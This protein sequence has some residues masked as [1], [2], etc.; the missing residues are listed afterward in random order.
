[1]KM[2]TKI[3]ILSSV[4][5]FFCAVLLTS[6][7]HDDN[8]VNPPA[9]DVIFTKDSLSLWMTSPNQLGTDSSVFSLGDNTLTKVK[10]EFEVISN[11]DGVN[12][13]GRFYVL[14]NVSPLLPLEDTLRAVTDISYTYVADVD[15]Q[16]FYAIYHLNMLTGT[17]PSI[18]Y[19]IKIKNIKIT[20]Q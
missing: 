11:S 3:L 19:Y 7:G 2:K 14:S 17:A 10:I 18:P 12:G 15:S 16:P 5:S 13:T 1:M 20:R 6:C 4:I 9:N 8:V